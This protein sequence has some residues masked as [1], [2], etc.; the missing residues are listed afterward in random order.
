M[1]F[2]LQQDKRGSPKTLP[3]LLENFFKV[4]K[5]TFYFFLDSIILS[6]LL[7]IRHLYFL[8]FVNDLNC[9]SIHFYQVNPNDN[10]MPRIVG[11][12]PFQHQFPFV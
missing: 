7:I 8:I 2:A 3:I 10:F 9:L 12:V 11:A 5:P 4:S 1:F 6:E